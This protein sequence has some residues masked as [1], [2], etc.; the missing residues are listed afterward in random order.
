MKWVVLWMIVFSLI[1]T[2]CANVELEEQ[3]PH[4]IDTS[5]EGNVI[6]EIPENTTEDI[7]ESIPEDPDSY[8]KEAN[9]A[10]RTF[11]IQLNELNETSSLMK[12][13]SLGDNID[14]YLGKSV[15]AK[16]TVSDIP[17]GKYTLLSLNNK[18]AQRY[19]ANEIIE[20]QEPFYVSISDVL[21][22]EEGEKYVSMLQLTVFMEIKEKYPTYLIEKD[23]GLH[24][25]LESRK[26]GNKYTALYHDTSVIVEENKDLTSRYTNNEHIIEYLDAQLYQL[27]DK[28]GVAWMSARENVPYLVTVSTNSESLIKAY[29]G[30]FPSMITPKTFCREKVSLKEQ[31]ERIFL[32]KDTSIKI[33]AAAISDSTVEAKLIINNDIS[34]RLGPKESTMVD[35][36]IIIVD[37]IEINYDGTD[38]RVTLCFI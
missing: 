37:S 28:K 22:N 10:P 11:T 32:Y 6:K 35:D 36:I 1:F 27:P 3:E 29:L 16:I 31:E 33:N 23:I 17:S 20:I 34:K 9:Q 19:D 30:L 21:Y 15:I 5:I 14:F 24:E 13:V 7:E 8:F 4:I 26:S 25:Y 12:T 18:Q 38:D 2:A